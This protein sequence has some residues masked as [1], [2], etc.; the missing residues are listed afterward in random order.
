MVEA[1]VILLRIKIST[2]DEFFLESIW[3]YSRKRYHF[4]RT[5]IYH[6]K[7]TYQAKMKAEELSLLPLY[8]T[9][10]FFNISD[11]KCAWKNWYKWNLKLLYIH[12]K[13]LCA[14]KHKKEQHQTGCTLAHYEM[15]CYQHSETNRYCICTVKSQNIQKY[16]TIIMHSLFSQSDLQRS[17]YPKCTYFI[18]LAH[19]VTYSHRFAWEI[20]HKF[21]VTL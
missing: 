14:Q 18:V 5:G 15:M 17:I 13:F 4:Y 9:T 11:K 19:N 16:W 12:L 2:M 21:F 20:L 10:A 8:K 6:S 1:E 7:N 3:I